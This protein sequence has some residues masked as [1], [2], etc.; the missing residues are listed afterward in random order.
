[1][2]WRTTVTSSCFSG[3]CFQQQRETLKRT[4]PDRSREQQGKKITLLCTLKVTHGQGG[5]L[6]SQVTASFSGKRWY[7]KKNKKPKKKSTSPL[8][9]N[10]GKKKKTVFRNHA[11]LRAPLSL[12]CL[13]NVVCL[14][15]S[16]N[17][18]SDGGRDPA[19]AW[20]RLVFSSQ[21]GSEETLP[22]HVVR[23]LPHRQTRATR[24]VSF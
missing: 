11:S 15:A 7:V 20:L 18:S 17:S 9:K 6:P 4:P 22:C 2:S 21:T 24:L 8:S 14:D 3:K 10:T 16:Q 13:S 19:S 23:T 5:I 12:A 1:M